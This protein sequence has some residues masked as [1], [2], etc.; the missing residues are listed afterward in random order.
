METLCSVSPT[1]RMS[2]VHHGGGRGLSIKPFPKR[3]N[4]TT[5][6]AAQPSPQQPGRQHQQRRGGTKMPQALPSKD[7]PV[8]TGAA[9]LAQA[10]LRQEQ[11]GSPDVQPSGQS[12]PA[13]RMAT[14]TASSVRAL[15]HRRVA[16]GRPSAHEPGRIR[17]QTSGSALQPW[18]G[19]TPTNPCRR[20]TKVAMV[21]PRRC[22][23]SAFRAA[24]SR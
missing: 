15:A 22:T 5:H 8:Q 16:R 18:L 12:R 20:K 14:P 13:A 17:G 3:A 2:V 1:M 4:S 7:K 6:G 19:R 11:V 23:C 10:R 24:H 21:A 9:T